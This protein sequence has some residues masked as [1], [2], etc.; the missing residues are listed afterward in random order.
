MLAIVRWNSCFFILL[1][2]AWVDMVCSQLGCMEYIRRLDYLSFQ[3]LRHVLSRSPVLIQ[4][5]RISV[6][7][8][9]VMSSNPSELTRDT[10]LEIF[11]LF[12]ILIFAQSIIRIYY[13]SA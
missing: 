1:L 2:I 6:L 7:L 4:L 13:R 9:Q 10:I 11:L 12:G 5:R 8:L 3:E